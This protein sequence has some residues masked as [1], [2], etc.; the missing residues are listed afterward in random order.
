VT[1]IFAE[2]HNFGIICHEAVSLLD[3]RAVL[4]VPRGHRRN[5]R[6]RVRRAVHSGQAE[7][8]SLGLFAEEAKQEGAWHGQ[9]H[10]TDIVIRW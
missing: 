7:I 1:F 3:G 10:A 2:R 8:L 9:R 4:F 5:C 6:C